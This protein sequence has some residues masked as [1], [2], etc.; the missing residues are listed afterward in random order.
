VSHATGL[1]Q[2]VARIFGIRIRITVA[3]AW[4]RASATGIGPPMVSPR[5]AGRVP[6]A[7]R[8]DQEIGVGTVQKV[9]S[10]G[11]AVAGAAVSGRGVPRDPEPGV[12]RLLRDPDARCGSGA[13]PSWCSGRRLPEER[14]ALVAL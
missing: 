2:R 12:V 10:A 3:A 4:Q 6:G 7:S 13:L 11:V 1:L 14:R 8:G 5:S 9:R